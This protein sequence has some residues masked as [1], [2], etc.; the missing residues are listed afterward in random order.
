MNTEN[1]YNDIKECLE[2]MNTS[3]IVYIHNQYCDAAKYYDNEI[4]DMSD[5]DELMSNCDPLEIARKCYY[6]SRF[7]PD[8]DYFYFN[9]YANC[10]TF[11]YYQDCDVISIDEI[12]K[13][14]LDNDEDFNNDEIRD[15]LDNADNEEGEN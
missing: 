10:I 7:C 5:F 9:G 13:Y 15:I 14:I 8:D 6:T 4:Y 11:D 3:D 12:T 2:N 1:L